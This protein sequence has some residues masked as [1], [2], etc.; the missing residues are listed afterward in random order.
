MSNIWKVVEASIA[1]ADKVLLYGPP[2]TGKTTAGCNAGNPDKIYKITLHE[3]MPA[4]ELQGHFIPDGN[5]F[6]W[7]DGV[8]TKAWREGARLILDEIDRASGDV[9]TMLYAGLDDSAVAALTLPTNETVRPSEGFQ[10]VA[11]MNGHPKDL[12]AALRDRFN[13]TIEIKEPNPDVFKHLSDEIRDFAKRDIEA[14][15]KRDGRASVRS[16]LSFDSLRGQMGPSMAA[17]VCFNDGQNTVIKD[18]VKALG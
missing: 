2:G 1:A 7:H 8:L 12:P 4:A 18:A 9:L 14:S 13:A 6:V 3:E 11:T 17:Q 5:K 10:V 15:I 16:W